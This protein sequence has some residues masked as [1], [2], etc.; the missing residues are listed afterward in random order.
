MKKNR[1]GCLALFVVL[2]ACIGHVSAQ[3]LLVVGEKVAT[4]SV[5][6][7]I[8]QA[9]V[10]NISIGYK[11]IGSGEPLLLIMGLG[12]T[13]EQWPNPLLD[14]LSKHYQLILLDNRGMG[15]STDNNTPFDYRLFAD[16]VIGLLDALH[17]DQTNVLGYSMGSTITQEL[18]LKYPNRINKAVL[19]ATTTNGGEV[20]EKL[21]AKPVTD[22][23][24]VRQIEA[25]AHWKTPLDQLALVKNQVM[26]AVGT[27]DAT[28]GTQSSQLIATTI[29]GAWLVQFKN[30]GHGFMR[31][32]P[33]AFAQT[34]V[35]FLQVDE[36]VPLP[37][38]ATPLQNKKPNL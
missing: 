16:D 11:V 9:R 32:I 28:V 19:L 14:A 37:N 30:G 36:T 3:T 33:E 20:A 10:N 15:H 21:K 8:Y 4:D 29:P 31:D 1:M 22:P 35:T 7:A 38:N 12:G 17:I 27:S 6:R 2:S 18:L 34:V 25:S 23:T 24:V 5:G 26:L 13:M